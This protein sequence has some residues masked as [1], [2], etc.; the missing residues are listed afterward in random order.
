M[1]K[2]GIQRFS[3]V[4]NPKIMSK[5]WSELFWPKKLRFFGG[6]GGGVS[7]TEIEILSDFDE[8]WSLGV[9]EGADFKNRIKISGRTFFDQK[10]WILE[11]GGRSPQKLTE[12]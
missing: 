8:I 6:G 11:G 12:N 7:P 1:L 9:F 3:K 4:L 2:F 10:K 5:F